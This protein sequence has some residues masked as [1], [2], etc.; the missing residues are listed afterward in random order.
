MIEELDKDE[1]VNL[2]SQQGELD[3]REKDVEKGD[4]AKEI[5]WNDPT[6]LRYHALQNRPFSKTEDSKIEKEVIKR[7]GFHLQQEISK[8]QKLDQQTKEKEEEFEAQADS[9]QKV[10]EMKLYMRIVP[11]EDIAIDAI[12]LATKPPVII[13]YKIVKPT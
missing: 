11:D 8:K 4:Q 2:V 12:P 7:Y 5:D 9:D 13:E 1:D 10:K 3:K 6:M